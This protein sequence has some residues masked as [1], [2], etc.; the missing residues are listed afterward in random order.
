MGRA[1]WLMQTGMTEGFVA[2]MDRELQSIV[3]AG[4]GPEGRE[5]VQAFLDRRK[6][7]FQKG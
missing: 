7:D 6:P 4:E 2:Q 3:A 1:R 5:G